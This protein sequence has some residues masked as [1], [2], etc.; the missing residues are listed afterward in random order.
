MVQILVGNAIKFTPEGG[1]IG[2]EVQGYPE[3]QQ[4]QISVW[5]TGI[6]LQPEDTQKL[7]QP[8]IQLDT[9]LSRR[10]EGAD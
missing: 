9:T 3:T 4:V 2:I 10:Y 8:F 6:G 7:F 5:D 1:E